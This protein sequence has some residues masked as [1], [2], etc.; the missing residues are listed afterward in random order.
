MRHIYAIAADKFMPGKSDDFKTLVVGMFLR[1]PR[2][3][4]FSKA[5]FHMWKG[6][7]HAMRGNTKQ[8]QIEFLAGSGIWG[9]GIANDTKSNLKLLNEIN[10]PDSGH[11]IFINH[12][13]EM[14]FA[15]DCKVIQKPFLANQEIKNT[16]VAY[17]WMKAMGSEVFDKSDQRT[18][19]KSV[20]NLLKGLK[21]QSYIVYP[22]G[23]N[24]YNEEIHS[25]KKG[26]IN[27][28][29]KLKIPI[30][31]VLKSGLTAFQ[32]KSSGNTIVYKS[33]G[34]IKPENFGTW[35]ELRDHIFDL[36]KTE[37]ISLDEERSKVVS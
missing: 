23:K 36:M 30:L 37:K 2:F 10:V 35:E 20:K 11:F 33:C 29:H 28:A 25:L 8:K 13:N 15:F 34:I 12:V 3:I 27:L 6:V 5:F 19:A 21:N 26:M 18:I 7:Y 31:V 14:D 9:N 16:Y 4:L 22:E 17:W 32:E 24:T 1:V